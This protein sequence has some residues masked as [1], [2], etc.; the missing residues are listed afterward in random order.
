M[1]STH[2]DE[3]FPRIIL[4]DEYVDMTIENIEKGEPMAVYAS[5]DSNSMFLYITF[6]NLRV[7]VYTFAAGLLFS[8]GTYYFLFINGV[9][10]GAFQYFFVQR[11]VFLDSFL[12][13]WI[14]GTIEISCIIIAGA[15]GIALGKSFLY[16]GTLPRK[17]SLVIGAKDSLKILVGVFPLIMLAGF[18]ESFITRLTDSP[19]IFRFGII[20]FSLC[21]IIGYFVVYPIW[22]SRNYGTQKTS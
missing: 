6:N 1:V 22:L 9:M 15:A 8:L 5:H 10:L 2:Y 4:G 14:H 19:A 12:S 16:P 11:D 21:F 7:S 17:V 3:S 13:I 18:L 20:F